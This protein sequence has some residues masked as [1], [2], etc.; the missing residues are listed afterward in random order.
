MRFFKLFVISIF[1]LF[2]VVFL[3]SLLIPPDAMVERTGVIEAPPATVY[4]HLGDLRHWKS[5]YPM[6]AED[7]LWDLTISNPSNAAGANVRWTNKQDPSDTGRLTLMRV[8]S[9]AGVYYR[10][11]ARKGQLADGGIEFKSTSDGKSTAIHW[12]VTSHLG[13]MPWWKFFGFVAD[14]VL[15]PQM[16]SAL[17]TLRDDCEHR[18]RSKQVMP[19][20]SS[21]PRPTTSQA[22]TL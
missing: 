10:L 6:F 18:I 13:Y 22:T 17:N 11:V 19:A 21:S 3:L 16:E 4:D 1:G 7:S 2:V 20:D 8:D 9:T 14:R 15:G 12:Y 5:W